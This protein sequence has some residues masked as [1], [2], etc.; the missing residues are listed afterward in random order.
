[1]ARCGH[2]DSRGP[3]DS[4]KNCFREASDTSSLHWCLIS[5][6]SN[7]KPKAV[8]ALVASPR[9]RVLPR[10]RDYRNFKT[11][12][13]L[14]PSDSELTTRSSPP[15]ADAP[16]RQAEPRLAPEI[17]LSVAAVPRPKSPSL[18][19]PVAI[20]KSTDLR[21]NHPNPTMPLPDPIPLK[22]QFPRINTRPSSANGSPSN[23][24][25]RSL[26]VRNSSSAGRR[27]G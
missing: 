10:L 21:L 6:S 15:R 8:G 18:S 1:M 14:T 5:P 3:S 13:S 12:C 9:K 26:P 25:P 23:D 17:P 16:K 27:G 7:L 4:R 22:I 2:L 20:S 24:R 11:R 19:A